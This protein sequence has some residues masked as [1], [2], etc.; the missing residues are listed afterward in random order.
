M[1]RF[2]ALGCGLLASTLWLGAAGLAQAGDQI[3]SLDAKLNNA[4]HPVTL[5]LDKGTYEVKPIQGK[6]AS[7][8]VWSTTNCTRKRGCERT[9]PTRFT[10]MHNNYYVASTQLASAKVGDQNVPVV[11]QMPTERTASYFLVLPNTNAYEVAQSVIYPD[12]QSALAAAQTSTFMLANPA[13]VQF[14]LFDNS[15]VNDNRGGMTLQIH[16]VE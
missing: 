1:N 12:E 5:K 7:W 13:D 15:R 3:V 4:A 8:S 11:S 10:G 9:T 6:F 2:K 16:K 14:A